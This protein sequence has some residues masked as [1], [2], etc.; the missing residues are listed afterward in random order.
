MCPVY[1]AY[2]GT[3]F[4]GICDRLATEIICQAVIYWTLVH[5]EVACAIGAPIGKVSEKITSLIEPSYKVHAPWGCE[6]FM[7]SDDA[8]DRILTKGKEIV[9]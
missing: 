6:T 9:L 5:S 4:V 2:R 8:C 3:G 7:Y 1:P